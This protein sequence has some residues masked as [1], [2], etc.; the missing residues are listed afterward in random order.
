MATASTIQTEPNV[1]C[2]VQF[3]NNQLV[4]TDWQHNLAVNEEKQAEHVLREF[5]GLYSDLVKTDVSLFIERKSNTITQIYAEY[6][7]DGEVVYSSKN[8]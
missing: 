1:D 3:W 4:F 8:K 7:R 2:K 6:S 5:S